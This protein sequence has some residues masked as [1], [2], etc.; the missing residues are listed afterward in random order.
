MPLGVVLGG[1]DVDR[2]HLLSA[3]LD[4]GRVLLVLSWEVTTK[5]VW[6]EVEAVRWVRAL[7]P[8]SGATCA[9]GTTEEARAV[10]AASGSESCTYAPRHS[11]KPPG[12][13][14]TSPLR[15][16]CTT[17]WGLDQSEWGSIASPANRSRSHST[18]EWSELTSK[19]LPNRLGWDRKQ[20]ASP[21]QIP[22]IVR[23][24]YVV[25]P[26]LPQLAKRLNADGQHPLSAP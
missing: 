10:G 20:C 24:V 8:K 5:R 21:E 26:F 19:L 11:R 12:P 3:D 14:K 1:G 23:L 2:C 18:R 6:M 4:A 22:D 7:T 9:G 16:K 25:A 13:A 17:G 15:S